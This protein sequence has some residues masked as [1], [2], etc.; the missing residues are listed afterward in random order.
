MTHP[1]EIPLCADVQ[2]AIH[3]ALGAAGLPAEAARHL[4]TCEAC[5]LEAESLERLVGALRSIPVVEPAWAFWESLP[6]R[7]LD[8]VHARQRRHSWA[9]RALAAAALL[10]LTI[11]PSNRTGWS[12]RSAGEWLQELAVTESWHDPLDRVHSVEEAARVARHVAVAHDF[13]PSAIQRMV[14]VTEEEAIRRP[15]ILAWN[16]LDTLGPQELERVVARVKKGV[17]R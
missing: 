6:G 15:E 9:L 4:E 12:R 7:V 1:S 8:T 13:G 16:L 17:E 2:R 5:G 10:L 3:E 14:H 11:I